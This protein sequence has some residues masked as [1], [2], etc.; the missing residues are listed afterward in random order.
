VVAQRGQPDRLRKLLAVLSEGAVQVAPE[1]A[2]RTVA[3]AERQHD[4][5]ERLHVAGNPIA[6]R[7][8]RVAD[9]P[10]QA[11]ER[12]LIVF[13]GAI[14]SA[15]EA[16]G[17]ARLSGHDSMDHARSKRERLLKA[18]HLSARRRLRFT[19][20]APPGHSAPLNDPGVSRYRYFQILGLASFTLSVCPCRL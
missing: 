17:R 9:Y 11:I 12:A 10:L 20:L 14:D 15:R 19:A 4:A 3:H 16:P 8:G 6:T 2:T 7:L 18:R 5:K 1:L 13:A